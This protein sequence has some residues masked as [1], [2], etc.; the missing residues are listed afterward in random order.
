MKS[1]SKGFSLIEVITALMILSVALIS[2]FQ[3]ITSVLISIK[4]NEL[5]YAAKEIASNRIALINTIEKPLNNKRT[6]VEVFGG[7]EFIWEE[8]FST[9]K[10]SFN[11]EAIKYSIL[12]K[13]RNQENYIYETTGLIQK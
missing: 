5:I 13:L 7:S 2:I 3:A 10:N 12:I 8:Y 1:S 11:Q 9:S 6:G 4:N